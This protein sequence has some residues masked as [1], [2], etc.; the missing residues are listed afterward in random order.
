[1]LVYEEFAIESHPKH[2]FLRGSQI[3]VPE[4][5]LL[6][7]GLLI[8]AEKHVLGQHGAQLFHQ[9]I[10]LE[11]VPE[12]EDAVPHG[13]DAHRR[14]HEP[15]FLRGHPGIDAVM[16]AADEQGVQDAVAGLLVHLR[17]V[18]HV[19]QNYQHLVQLFHPQLLGLLGDLLLLGH[20][21]AQRALV[22]LVPP[23]LLSVGVHSELLSDVFF[24]RF[25]L[26]VHVNAVAH[27]IHPLEAAPVLLE[28]HR[29]E[30]NGLPGS[31]R[32]AEDAV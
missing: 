6:P 32:G 23:A 4:A 25:P 8:H 11:L 5:V 9:S 30:E 16:P 1:M 27:H 3:D 29:H 24:H 15:Q 26:R 22:P 20:D 17:A 13:V 7:G 12:P 2:V 31:R 28:D 21:L 10:Q 18:C 19:V 14:R